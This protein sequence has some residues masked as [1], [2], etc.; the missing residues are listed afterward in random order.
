MEAFPFTN[1]EW[2]PLKDL[3]DSILNANSAKDDALATSL[4]L[5]LLEQLAA[6]RVRHGD[7]PVLLETI[8]DY[9]EDAAEQVVLYRQAIE[10]AE[11]HGLPTLSIRMSFAPVLVE[12]GEPMGALEELQA[13]GREAAG[14]SADE[15][16]SWLWEL[17]HVALEAASD[18]QRSTL[19]RLAE[20]IAR[21]H[22]LPAL[23]IRLL[24]I[25]FLLDI[26]QLAAA[27][28]ELHA[29]AGEASGGS[30]DDRAF[31]AQLCGEASQAES[32]ATADPADHD[33]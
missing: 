4:R 31:W 16:E 2:D 24:H 17:K 14:G 22:G 21:T 27:R 5:D 30:E 11:A 26:G 9:T 13:C 10:V 12:L 29:C 6:L 19:Y 15:R 33:R 25:R 3:A 7:H 18:A 23:R 32:G 1:A 8:A 28:E 20:E